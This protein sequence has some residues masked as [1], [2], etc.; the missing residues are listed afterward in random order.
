MIL[1]EG[2][3]YLYFVSMLWSPSICKRLPQTP[4]ALPGGRIMVPL[5]V[6]L[7]TFG[8]LNMVFHM[9]KGTL[10]MWFRMSRWE[11]TPESSRWTQCN[12]RILNKRV[13]GDLELERKGEVILEATGWTDGSQ[14]SW[15]KK[16]RWCS[17][18]AKGQGMKPQSVQKQPLPLTASR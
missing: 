15:A 9:I 10:W 8:T 14:E 11:M 7:L 16:C 1:E 12:H 17:E 18:T 6:H 13:A 4:S 3:G 5:D 2:G